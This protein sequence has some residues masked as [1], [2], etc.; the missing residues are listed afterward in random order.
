MELNVTMG[1]IAVTGRIRRL[2]IIVIFFLQA[3]LVVPVSRFGDVNTLFQVVKVRNHMVVSL[4]KLA[5]LIAIH[6]G[7]V[8]F[9]LFTG[10]HW[11]DCGH[12]LRWYIS[13]R[14]GILDWWPR[15]TPVLNLYNPPLLSS[16][17]RPLTAFSNSF[18]CNDLF[19]W[20]RA[21]VDCLVDLLMTVLCERGLIMLPHGCL[22]TNSADFCRYWALYVWQNIRRVLVWCTLLRPLRSNRTTF[23]RNLAV[24]VRLVYSS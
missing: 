18:W 13:C 5:T 16:A 4:A 19:S 1:T 14:T 7:S 11:S 17:F 3:G 10:R 6:E 2:L 9:L 15:R 20:W 12:H 22:H 24:S 21:S 8:K 23:G